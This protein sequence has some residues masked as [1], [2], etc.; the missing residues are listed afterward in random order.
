MRLVIYGTRLNR[1]STKTFCGPMCEGQFI[2]ATATT[3]T[4]MPI[5]N[6]TLK[7]VLM[8]TSSLDVSWLPKTSGEHPYTLYG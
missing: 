6:I 7:R 2:S 1:E 5:N 3:A 4:H 8:L